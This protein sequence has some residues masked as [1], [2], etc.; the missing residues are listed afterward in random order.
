MLPFT[1]MPF[2][3]MQ[4]LG[5]DFVVLD[6][7]KTPIVLEPQQIIRIADRRLGVGCDQV[8]VLAPSASADVFMGIYNAD[9]TEVSACGNATRCVGWLLAQELGRAEVRIQTHAGL[10]LANAQ[11]KTEVTVNMGAPKLAWQEIPLASACDTL[12]LPL[13]LEG[14]SDPVGVSMG[15]PHAV[16]FVED[17]TAVPLAEL[18]AKLE[19]HPLFPERANISIAQMQGRGDITLRVWERGAGLTQACGTAA[20]AALVA[21]VRRGLA[22]SHAHVHLPGGVLE[23]AWGGGVADPVMMT[24]AVEVSFAGVLAEDLV[25]KN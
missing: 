6:A 18:G 3:K 23:I 21:A 25:N 13:S 1:K 19:H 10:L 9:G 24:G 7:R 8:I 15:N 4:G 14:L 2:T 22:E 17:V 5:N 16:F 11:S 20:C 12:H